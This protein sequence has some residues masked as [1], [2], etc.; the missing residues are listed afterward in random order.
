MVDHGRTVIKTMMVN[1]HDSLDIHII[2]SNMPRSDPSQYFYVSSQSY[3]GMHSPPKWSAPHSLALETVGD[4]MHRLISLLLAPL[5]R[6]FASCS[7]P[8]SN[9]LS[10]LSA[11]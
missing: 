2:H 6:D 9:S 8:V 3:L 1:H 11:S 7:Y 5:R 4:V 10:F